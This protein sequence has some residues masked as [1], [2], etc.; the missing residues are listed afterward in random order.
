MRQATIHLSDAEL[1]SLGLGELVSLFREAGLR[2]VRELRCRGSGCLLVIAV[3]EAVAAD[4]LR[5]R[6]DVKW[7]ERVDDGGGSVTYL[8][9]IAVPEVGDAVEPYHETEVTQREIDPTGG[10]LDV[11]ILGSHEAL[12]ERVDEYE[13]AGANVLL[14]A[15]SDYE[16]PDD[17][18]DATTP[19]QREVLKTAFDLGYFDVPREATT[20][21]VG[22]ELDLD[23]ST[24][25]EHLQRAQRNL[26]AELL[27]DDG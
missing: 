11:T 10:G 27:R 5:A 25:R 14:R 17:P 9:K 21:A 1:A 3:E 24:V 2:R 16:G 13:A 15:L 26:L 7:F 4:R 23:P 12:G 20:E 22:N 6:S 18:L 8:C 19:R